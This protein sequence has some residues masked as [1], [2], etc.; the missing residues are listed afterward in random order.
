MNQNQNTNKNY[1]GKTHI[2]KVRSENQDNFIITE[3]E[4]AI[5][6]T[7]CDGMG[8]ENGGSIASEIAT[9]CYNEYLSQKIEEDSENA[10]VP[11][12]I[13][14]ML[15]QA[16]N[17]AHEKVKERA[18]KN[19]ELEG[20]GTT[21]VSAFVTDGGTYVCNIGD[22][23]CYIVDLGEL[24]KITKDHSLV[25]ELVDAGMLTEEEAENHPQKNCITRAIGV[26]YNMKP[27]IFFVPLFDSLLLCS[28]GLT[29]MVGND[30]IKNIILDKINPQEAV[31]KLVSLALENGG[32]DNVT[33]ALIKT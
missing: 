16:V 23:R 18:R 7:V 6:L 22:S 28:D 26:D 29:N 33:V 2:G 13:C 8:G 20:M 21:L 31:E 24:R 15:A 5:C 27:D 10:S 9:R 4:N 30:E 3:Y 11:E 19:E 17:Y 14:L 25:G 1:Y 32:L 12:K